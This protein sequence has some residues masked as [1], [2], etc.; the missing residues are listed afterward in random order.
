[1]VK[2]INISYY[3]N[4]MQKFGLSFPTKFGWITVEAVEDRLT[5]LSFSNKKLKDENPMLVKLKTDLTRYFEGEKVDF[6]RYKVNLTSYT[7]FERKVLTAAKKLKCGET[8]TYGNLA[9]KVGH[10]NAQRA[11]GTVMSKNNVPIIIPCHRVIATSGIGG[12]TGDL[13]M[14]R[15]LLAL[16][17]VRI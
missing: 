5:R 3:A 6:G 17:N 13:N 4:H 14:K 9:K 2:I 1:M 10:K 12:F 8:I 15:R 11:V 7:E 16:E